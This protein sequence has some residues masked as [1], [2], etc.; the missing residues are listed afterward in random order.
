[1]IPV[2]RSWMV[3]DL[4]QDRL[5][6]FIPSAMGAGILLSLG[7]LVSDAYGKAGGQRLAKRWSALSARANAAE[8]IAGPGTSLTAP[9]GFRSSRTYIIVSGA[10][11]GLVAW[12]IPGAT[13]NYFN[14]V[15]YVKGVAWL[16]AIGVLTAIFFARVGFTV[17]QAVPRSFPPVVGAIG[18]GL[19]ARFAQ[20]A[21]G[22]VWKL[23]VV[24]LGS[25]TVT[26]IAVYVANNYARSRRALPAWAWPFF[27]STPLSS[28][29]RP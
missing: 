22:E 14:P 29:E 21:A 27:I 7:I 28:T 6:V 23:V 24:G 25:L 5:H 15:G 26:I 9:V 18:L 4:D 11:L 10:S 3:D 17:A 20:L 8:V 16:W 13:W 1:M 2:R 12:L 19:T